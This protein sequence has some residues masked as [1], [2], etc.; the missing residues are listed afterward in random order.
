MTDMLPAQQTLHGYM[1][2]YYYQTGGIYS[3]DVLVFRGS[4]GDGYPFLSR[5]IPLSFI[6]VAGTIV[7]PNTAML[8]EADAKCSC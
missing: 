1:I 7:S 5:A 3:P 2:Q 8:S 6:S 4:E